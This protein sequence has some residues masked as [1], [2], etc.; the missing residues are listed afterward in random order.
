MPDTVPIRAAVYTRVEQQSVAL[1]W[2]VYSLLI[3]SASAL[4]GGLWDLSWHSSIGR[5]TFWT[6]AH[7]L[8][9]FCAVLGAITCA[10]LILHATFSKDVSAKGV[11]VGVLGFHGPFAAFV[12]MWGAAAMLVS[13]PFDNWWHNAYGL[14]VQ[15][16]SPPHTLLGLGVMCVQLGGM[17]LILGSRNRAEG[18]SRSLLDWLFLCAAGL[19][20]S[21]VLFT[22]L[23][24]TLRVFMHSAIFYRAVSIGVPIVL[25]GAAQASEKRWAATAVA[26]V[27][28]ASWLAVRLIL[29]LFP[30][31]PKLGPVYNPVTHY[32]GLFF[33]LLIIAPAI[34]L[35]LV[36]PW[37]R[38]RG[39]WLQ[40]FVL[41]A[42]FLAMMVAVQWPFGTFLMS[43][44]SRNWFFGTGELSYFWPPESGMARHVFYAYEPTRGAFSLGMG[45]AL[46][47]AIL[48]SL[49]G[50]G[51]AKWMREVRR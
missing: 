8:T 50:L 47:C 17:L 15:I 51:W 28:T 6:P 36:R 40:A 33:P 35:D 10:I 34:G 48:S 38:N 29:R 42:V 37:I 19:L 24:Y 9:Q 45:I 43:P 26:G 31:E 14:D 41:G 12:V 21:S 30:A 44:A 4:V 3:A 7:L 49:L 39:K 13:A 22:S 23:E 11:S 25:I 46:A 5:D 32:V 20:L 2:Y 16:L 27:Y 18:R 1:R